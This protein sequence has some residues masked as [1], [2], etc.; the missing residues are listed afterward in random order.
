MTQN[1]QKQSKKRR[2]PTQN[3]PKE[4]KTLKKKAKVGSKGKQK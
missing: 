1:K 3:N 2:K 4:V